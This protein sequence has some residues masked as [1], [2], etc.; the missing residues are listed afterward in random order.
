MAGVS[1]CFSQPF[2]VGDTVTVGGEYG[3]VEDI[4]LLQSVFTTF[5]NRRIIIPNES[6]ASMQVIN[7]TIREEKTR[8]QVP[9][10][11]D[12][13]ADVQRAREILIEIV[14]DS[15]NWDRENEPQVWFME[16]GQQ[17]IKLWVVAWS[18]N[19][20]KSFELSCHILDHALRR[21]KEEGIALPR[22]RFESVRGHDADEPHPVGSAA[23]GRP[24]L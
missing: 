6:L 7:H 20:G 13:E 10:F 19:P 1:L 9:I 8:V 12:Y 4:S 5:D 14:R 21:F 18:E 24:K 3:R 2:R 17:T 16:M 22:Q 15:P 23:T 11:L